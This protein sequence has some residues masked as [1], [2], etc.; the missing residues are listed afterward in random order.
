MTQEINPSTGKPFVFGEV[1]FDNYP[2]GSVPH[3]VN[4]PNKPIDPATGLPV[5][6]KYNQMDRGTKQWE[7]VHE[8]QQNFDSGALPSAPVVNQ[9]AFK[10][11]STVNVQPFV[12]HSSDA[13]FPGPV[14]VPSNPVVLSPS[15]VAAGDKI[16]NNTVVTPTGEVVR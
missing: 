3:G 4:Y 8:D 11:A 2:N 12:D 14:G 5:G 1:G 16:V 13:S 6:Q 9:T 10:D 7:A 15:E